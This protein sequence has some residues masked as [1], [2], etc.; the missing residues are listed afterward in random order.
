MV[1]ERNEIIELSGGKRY[2]VT[3]MME[4]NYKW[5][6]YLLELDEFDNLIGNDKVI[7]TT[8]ENGRLFIKTVDS[9]NE[10]IDK[11]KNKLQRS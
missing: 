10:I 1:F 9:G 8:L 2:I 3:D 6:Y 7:T 11:L 5:Y 4:D